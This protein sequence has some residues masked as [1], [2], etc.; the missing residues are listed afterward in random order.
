[1]RIKVP[2]I[3]AF[4]LAKTQYLVYV[5]DCVIFAKKR[6]KIPDRLITSLKRGNEKMSLQ[7]KM[8]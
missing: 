2:L 5:N 4:L 6:S 1:M 3:H 8:E 7:M